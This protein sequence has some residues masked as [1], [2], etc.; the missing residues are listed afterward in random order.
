M[1][2]ETITPTAG[3]QT[4]LAKTP[5]LALETYTARGGRAICRPFLLRQAEWQGLQF[6]CAPPTNVVMIPRLILVLLAFCMPSPALA[7]GIEGLWDFRLDGVTIFRFDVRQTDGD[8]WEG[9]WSRPDDFRTDGYAFGGLIDP[10]KSTESMAG[11]EF[12]GMVELSYDDPRP[13]AIPDIFR[14]ELIDADNVRMT[15]VGTD[16][17]PYRLVRAVPDDPIGGWDP[18]QVFRRLR[19]DEEQMMVQPEPDAPAPA[20]EIIPLVEE[21][22]EPEPV[23]EPDE[24]PLEEEVEEEPAPRVGADF[25]EGL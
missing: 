11:Y 9:T 15:Y 18:S 13:G 24:P 3:V 19:P 20:L 14:F 17:S 21:E 22:A 12:L 4:A 2:R 6:L 10:I 16:L 7:Q 25:L 23:I 5:N 1:L 8:E